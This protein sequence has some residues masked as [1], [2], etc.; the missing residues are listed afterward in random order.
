MP[1]SLVSEMVL[2]FTKD[3][4]T[5]AQF[6]PDFGHFLSEGG[7]LSLQVGSTHGYLV[8]L[9]TAGIPGTLCRLVVFIPPGPVL[10]ILRVDREKQGTLMNI[11]LIYSDLSSTQ[12]RFTLTPLLLSVMWVFGHE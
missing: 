9:E 1:L 5:A 4:A 2:V 8:L 11:L 6:L 7:I 12:F 3:V 10:L